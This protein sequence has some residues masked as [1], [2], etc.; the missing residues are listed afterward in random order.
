MCNHSFKSELDRDGGLR[1]LSVRG[2]SRGAS[3]SQHVIDLKVF[4]FEERRQH[5]VHRLV[6][7]G[8]F[9][10]LSNY[11]TKELFTL[12]CSGHY[13]FGSKVRGVIIRL[14]GITNDE[15]QHNFCNYCAKLQ[16][17]CLSFSLSPAPQCHN[18]CNLGQHIQVIQQTITANKQTM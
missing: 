12:P 16:G 1:L 17:H 4:R 8:Y 9:C 18:S 14:K 3:L 5:I 10:K 2:I 7:F 13:W 15:S 11:H 6:V